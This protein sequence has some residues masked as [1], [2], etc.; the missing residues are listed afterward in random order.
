MTTGILIWWSPGSDPEHDQILT[1]C[2][3]EARRDI[4]D[5]VLNPSQAPAGFARA[6]S[7]CTQRIRHL[8]VEAIEQAAPDVEFVIAHAR[9]L[10]SGLIG[11]V[12]SIPDLHEATASRSAARQADLAVKVLQARERVES[13]SEIH[14]RHIA[15]VAASGDDAIAE[16]DRLTRVHHRFA[17]G[18]TYAVP[19]VAVPVDV[20]EIGLTRVR[21]ALPGLFA[22][23]SDDHTTQTH[24]RGAA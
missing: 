6:M 4:P 19:H 10:D 24:E 5:V 23:D 13:L 3:L 7:L 2:V 11:G 14:A 15:A 17:Y 1:D 20:F 21:T 18:L 16:I 9:V 12:S 22:S 8:Q